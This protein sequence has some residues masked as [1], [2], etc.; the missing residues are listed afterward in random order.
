[1]RTYFPGDDEKGSLCLEEKALLDRYPPAS[2]ELCVLQTSSFLTQARSTLCIE[3]GKKESDAL[4]WG[5]E[6]GLIDR[7]PAH[8]GRDLNCARP[9]DIF[10]NVTTST[11]SIIIWV[12]Y[13]NDVF[14]W[15]LIQHSSI[16]IFMNSICTYIKGSLIRVRN[17]IPCFTYCCSGQK[18]LAS[19]FMTYLF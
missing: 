3:P 19:T 15:D 11:L 13:A 6:E 12:L 16:C 5:G 7:R 14:Q 8:F 18:C 4:L 9:R 10:Y 1:M 17:S 2:N